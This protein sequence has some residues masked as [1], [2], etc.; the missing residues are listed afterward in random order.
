MLRVVSVVIVMVIG[1]N[2]GAHDKYVCNPNFK[3]CLN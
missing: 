1:I 3:I 2:I